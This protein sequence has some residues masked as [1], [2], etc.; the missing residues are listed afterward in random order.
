MQYFSRQAIGLSVLFFS[1]SVTASI[2]SWDIRYPDLAQAIETSADSFD[3]SKNVGIM[4]TL[5][6][7]DKALL[8]KTAAD[9]RSCTVHYQD[10]HRA[11]D[12]DD[13]YEHAKAGEACLK[14]SL[15][16]M[17]KAAAGSFAASG[18]ANAV[19]DLL[20]QKAE[21]ISESKEGLKDFM[22]I[23]F[24]VAFGVNFPSSGRVQAAKVVNNEIIVTE[25][26]DPEPL[27][28]LE[29]HYFFDVFN[30][31]KSTKHTKGLGPYFGITADS[32]DVLQG[33]TTGVMFG[34]KRKQ[35]PSQT[36]FEAMTVGIGAL[37]ERDVKDLA[38]GY[39]EGQPTPD[40]TTN[41]EFETESRVSP[42]LIF[43]TAF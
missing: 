13:I 11:T 5:S 2:N 27:I 41:I 30:D 15:I 22:G 35:N 29:T 38:K 43:G 36:V 37:L 16:Q 7:G 14:S 4:G 10:M 31:H 42:V 32:D 12:V 8:D 18:H 21:E 20:I 6:D 28:V 23:N 34:I 39:K 33:F 19:N 25:E 17:R 40:G 9:I 26:Y 3:V 1:V 24:G